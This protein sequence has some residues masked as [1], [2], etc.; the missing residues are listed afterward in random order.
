Q[1]PS[2]AAVTPLSVIRDPWL[3]QWPG[4]VYN[5]GFTKQWL[6]ERDRQASAGGSGWVDQR[7]E[8]DDETCAANQELREQNIDFEEFGRS[9]VN[10]PPAVD[11]RDLTELVRDIEVP[12]Y[13]SGAW[14]DEQSGPQ[15]SDM[16]TNFESAPLTRFTMFNGR[17]PD[18]YTPHL[19]G[20]WYEFLS[21]HVDEEVP[22]LPDSLRALAPTA[23]GDFFG[24]EGLTFEDDRFAD[25]DSDEFDEAYAEYEDEPD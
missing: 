24:V 3:Q 9:L 5:G 25:F 22:D 1:P 8:E 13:L 4:G 18:G 15:F 21:F 12:V 7:I 2:L 19:L 23:F 14:Q 20:R 16:L 11:D 10:R 17:H 6:A